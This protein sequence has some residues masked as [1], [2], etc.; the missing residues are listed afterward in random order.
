[1]KDKITFSKQFKMFFEHHGK[2]VSLSC[3]CVFTAAVIG[4]GAVH[5]VKKANAEREILKAL[6]ESAG[7]G[8]VVVDIKGAVKNEGVYELPRGSRLS[9]AAE[10]AGGF[11]DDAD[12]ER[13]NLAAPLEDGEGITVPSV[14]AQEDSA[15]GKIN[16]NTASKAELASLPGIGEV[17]AQRIVEYRDEKGLFTSLEQLKNIKGLGDKT[18]RELENL[19]TLE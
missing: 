2:A 14:S 16:I 12:R 1:M 5:A 9:D 19:I 4:V 11:T 15:N 10:A 7:T 13:L 3:F 6:N 17:T 8:T 18:F